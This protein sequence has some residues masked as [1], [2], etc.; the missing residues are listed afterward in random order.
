MDAFSSVIDLAGVHG[1]LDLRC[2]L[3][4]SFALDHEPA[5]A[6]EAAF[7]LV[8]AGHT[9]RCNCRW[10]HCSLGPAIL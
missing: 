9:R 5:P 1:S 3:A 4:G 10:S 8:L 6:G 2:L 7:H